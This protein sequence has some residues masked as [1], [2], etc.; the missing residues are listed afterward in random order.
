MKGRIF[1]LISLA[2]LLAGAIFLYYNFNPTE[3]TGKF[4]TCPSKSIFDI[5]CPGCGSQRAIHHLLHLNVQQAFVYNPLMV[6]LLPLTIALVVQFVLRNFFKIY[7]H[8]PLFY[9]NVFVWG[10]FVVFILYFIFRNVNIPGV[11]FL[12]PPA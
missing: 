12:K 10:L 6:I 2:L 7:W 5:Y 3:H 1:T 11:W 8:V 9:N 4:P